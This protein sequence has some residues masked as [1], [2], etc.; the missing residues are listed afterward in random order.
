[1]D[2]K[3][4]LITG[5]SGGMG[6]EIAKG[7]KDQFALALHAFSGNIHEQQSETI[8]HFTADLRNEEEC[9]RLIDEVV[10]HFGRI[11]ILINNAGISKSAMSWKM[12]SEDWSET[13]SINLNAPFYL[14]KYAI[15]HMR[16]HEWGRIINISSVVAQSGFIGTSAYAA[17]KAGLLGLT[18]TLAKELASSGITVNALAL[19][20]FNVGMIADVPEDIQAEII[21]EIPMKRL[22]DPQTVV[23][24][25]SWLSTEASDYITGQTINLNGGLLS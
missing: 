3:V 14:S 12:S 2:R 7:M 11:D 16:Q 9:K 1:M 18:K 4:V 10:K 24:T 23:G 5:A 22:G 15:P 13:L 20:Y 6:R 17:S 19:G 21:A 25:V 8:A